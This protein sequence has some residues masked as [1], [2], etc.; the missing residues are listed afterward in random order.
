M[1]RQPHTTRGSDALLYITLVAMTL[2][3]FGAFLAEFYGN[4][5]S[6]DLARQHREACIDEGRRPTEC[7]HVD[8]ALICPLEGVQP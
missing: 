1:S 8:G 7:C 2:A 3:G 4:S 6:R 5:A